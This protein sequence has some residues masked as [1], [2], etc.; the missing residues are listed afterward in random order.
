MLSLISLDVK[1]A[2][3]RVSKE[4]LIQRIRA[5]GIPEQLLRWIKAFCSNRAAII[6]V[7]G[8]CSK[9]RDLAQSGSPLSPVAYLLYNADLMQRRIDA[10]GGAMAFIDDF[11]AWV[12]GP[13][14]HSNR[15]GI[16]SII[17]T[18]TDWEKRS[19][20]TFEADKTNQP[21]PLYL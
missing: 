5:R 14:A 2:Y 16:A 7:K 9:T 20:A 13:A 1:G 3:N 21:H 18:A 6:L 11:S 17:E 12:T 19:G 8:R 10:N 4:G 15:A